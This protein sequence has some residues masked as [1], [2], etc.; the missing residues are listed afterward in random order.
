MPHEDQKKTLNKVWE[1]MPGFGLQS[2]PF[3]EK[4]D[5]QNKKISDVETSPYNY[6]Q[7]S[8]L[9]PYKD[10]M[11]VK[12]T[13]LKD[14]YKEY[15]NYDTLGVM[16]VIALGDLI[17]IFAYLMQYPVNQLLV[18][19]IEMPIL[20]ILQ[21]YMCYYLKNHWEEQRLPLNMKDGKYNYMFKNKMIHDFDEDHEIMGGPPKFEIWDQN[22]KLYDFVKVFQQNKLEELLEVFGRRQ[23]K[24]CIEFNTGTEKVEDDRKIKSWPL[25]P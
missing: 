9:T 3:D 14:K 8:Y 18:E 16:L 4:D 2:V 25:S 20:S 22:A 24:S 12:D 10:F 1:Y 17:C 11:M 13:R 15:M 19:C 5:D 23:C 7:H 21:I 6:L